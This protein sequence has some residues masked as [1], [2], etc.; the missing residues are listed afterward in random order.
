[1]PTKKPTSTW[2]GIITGIIGTLSLCYLQI[3]PILMDSVEREAAL[4]FQRRGVEELKIQMEELRLHGNE[5]PLARHIDG[6][7]D[8]VV[9][10]QVYH[11]RCVSAAATGQ[12]A[13]M[14]SPEHQKKAKDKI[15]EEP[16]LASFAGAIGVPVQACSPAP[17]NQCNGADPYTHATWDRQELVGSDGQGGYIYDLVWGHGCRQRSHLHANGWLERYP[18]GWLCCAH[19]G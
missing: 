5:E 18:Q 12:F 8:G 4:D 14:A 19:G 16:K 17:G 1:M 11:S 6:D 9:V 2:V 15:A 3:K 7:Q 13:F 10:T